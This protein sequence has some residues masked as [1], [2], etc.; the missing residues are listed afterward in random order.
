MTTT[1]RFA[2]EM[3]RDEHVGGDGVVPHEGRAPV[4]APLRDQ[5]PAI[6]FGDAE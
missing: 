5:V 3:G 6:G 1:E 2:V 4:V